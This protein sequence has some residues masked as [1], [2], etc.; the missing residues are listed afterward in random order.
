MG[1]KENEKARAA[2]R[3]FASAFQ[4]FIGVLEL[5]EERERD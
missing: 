1:E 3:D 5:R 2:K 4:I